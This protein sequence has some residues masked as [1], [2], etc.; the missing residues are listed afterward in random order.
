MADNVKYNE[1]LSYLKNHGRVAIAF[2]GGVDSSL[3]L[4]AASLAL[5][6]NILAISVRTPYIPSWELEEAVQFTGEHKIT[7]K[8]FDFPFRHQL[9]NNPK[10][11]C[12]WC[13]RNLFGFMLSEI[14]KEGYQTLMD[15]TNFDDLQDY[16][17]GLKALKELQIVSPFLEL[18]ITKKEIRQFSHEL[19][20]PTWQKPAYA[21]LLTRIP[22]DQEITDEALKQIEQGEKHLRDLGF[23]GSRVRVH[24]N[25][26]RI[27]IARENMEKMFDLEK[28]HKITTTFKSFGFGYV[29]LDMEGYRM[30]SHNES[31]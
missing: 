29:T 12:Y 28:F 17:P 10:E 22:Y 6:G 1:L 7:H 30:G 23:H 3:L 5:P 18:K 4:K 13:K 21:C 2:S 20:L 26:A 19:G 27:E 15:G 8:I 11:R 24:G 25:L 14:K 16:R 9:R 31:L